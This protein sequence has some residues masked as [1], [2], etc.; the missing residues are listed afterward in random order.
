MTKWWL[1]EVCF[2]KR[3]KGGVS[4]RATNKLEGIPQMWAKLD[5]FTDGLGT[6]MKNQEAQYF[7]LEEHRF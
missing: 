6:M 2:Q 3:F 4:G 7:I 5:E 1:K